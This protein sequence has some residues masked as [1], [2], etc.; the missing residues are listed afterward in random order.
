MVFFIIFGT[1]GVTY[2]KARGSF[3]CPQCRTLAPY[4]HRRIRRFFT[5]YFIPVI[6]LD[7]LGEYVECDQCRGTYKMEILQ[8]TSGM[9]GGPVA[10]G[11]GYGGS[12]GSTGPGGGQN[13]IV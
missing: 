12:T 6:P 8:L 2:T 7:L 4:R 3:Q 1:R 13:P 9:T 10:P 11:G 5:L